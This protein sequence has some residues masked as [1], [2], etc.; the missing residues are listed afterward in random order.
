MIYRESLKMC[1]LRY[2]RA[3]FLIDYQKLGVIKALQMPIYRCF[4]AM[5]TYGGKGVK[6][7]RRDKK[8]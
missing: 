2:L 3:F 5:P 4:K 7:V 1:L 8:G 6:R